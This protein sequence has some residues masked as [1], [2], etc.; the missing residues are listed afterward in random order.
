MDLPSNIHSAQVVQYADDVTLITTGKTVEQARDQMNKAL[1]EYWQYAT[2]N[3]VLPEP[4]KTQNLVIAGTWDDKEMSRAVANMAGVDIKP[5]KAIKILGV[6]LDHKLSW[7]PHNVAA[8]AKARGVAYR[9]YRAAR[10][11]P[12]K[13]RARLMRMLAHPIMDFAQPALTG[14]SEN[15]KASLN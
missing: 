7:E 1:R 11:L 13:D 12:R 4:G 6:L 2:A 8:A 15:A 9:V 14:A 5:R 10:E 3:R